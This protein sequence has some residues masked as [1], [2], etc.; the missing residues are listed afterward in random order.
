LIIAT[1]ITVKLAGVLTDADALPIV[2]SCTPAATT[3][4]VKASAGT[5]TLS[6]T[7]AV[8]DTTY[9]VA[10]SLL[11]D[12]T[13]YLWNKSLSASDAPP[14]TAV[15]LDEMKAFLRLIGTDHDVL[16]TSLILAGQEYIASECD[17]LSTDPT[18]WAEMP[19]LAVKMFVAGVFGNPESHSTQEVKE[20]PAVR[21]MLK[22]LSSWVPQ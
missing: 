11:I 19:K 3:S 22:L 1:T 8:A 16:L 2:T 9:A 17:T 10:G 13:P 12:A 6:I 21:R 7:D 14:S 4:I 15:T 5:Y 20:S 18:T